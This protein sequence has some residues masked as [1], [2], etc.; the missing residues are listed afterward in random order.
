[1]FDTHT[2][3]RTRIVKLG[4]PKLD[5]IEDMKIEGEQLQRTVKKIEL[6]EKSMFSHK[7]DK[8]DKREE[9]LALYSKK[10]EVI[11]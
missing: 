3:L 1:M 10:L 9:L 7:L 4:L 5:P 11:F 2:H 8:S 6:L